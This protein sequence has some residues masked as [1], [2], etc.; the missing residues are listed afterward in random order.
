[1]TQLKINTGKTPNDRSGDSLYAAFNKVNANFTELY[2]LTGGSVNN[3]KELIQDTVAEM[4]LNGSLS[5]IEI[6]YDDA[7]NALNI[8]SIEPSIDGGSASSTFTN[9]Q[10]NGGNA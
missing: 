4:I 6:N 1:M 9:M 5:G 3:L 2:T 8:Q 10:Y 7:H